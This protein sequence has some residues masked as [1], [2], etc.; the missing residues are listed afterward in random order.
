M[1]YEEENNTTCRRVYGVNMP[2]S[3]RLCDDLCTGETDEKGNACYFEMT[4]VSFIVW[5]HSWYFITT[6]WN[7]RV[8]ILGDIFALL[9]RCFEYYSI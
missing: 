7:F 3:F 1:F 4:F 2:V 5:L 9:V 6:S 8:Y